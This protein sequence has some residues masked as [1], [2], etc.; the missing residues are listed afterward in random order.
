MSRSATISLSTVAGA[1]NRFFVWAENQ[2]VITADGTTAPTK[3]VVL[4]GTPAAIRVRVFGIGA[5]QYQLKIDLPA[6]S[7]GI[8]Q[9]R[10]LD[11][12]YDEYDLSV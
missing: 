1:I 5:A 6:P 4:Q 2:R 9:T 11:E 8:K 7:P 3:T 12:G 10:T